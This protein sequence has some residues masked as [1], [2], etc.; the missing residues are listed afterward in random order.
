MTIWA[1]GRRHRL[2]DCSG[3][4]LR[5]ARTWHR[6]GGATQ[7]ASSMFGTQGTQLSY[8]GQ[9]FRLMAESLVGTHLVEGNI[10]NGEWSSVSDQVDVVTYQD[11][12][13][14]VIFVCAEELTVTGVDIQIDLSAFGQ[15]S[16]AW[17]ETI[18]TPADL[19]DVHD[20]ANMFT[21]Q[22]AKTSMPIQHGASGDSI[23]VDLV[24]DHEVV[25]IILAKATPGS[26]ALYLYGTDSRDRLVGGSGEDSLFG[27]DGYDSLTG[28]AG[29]D[30]LM[31]GAGNDS[32]IGEGGHDT[33]YGDAGAD[34]LQGLFG[35]DWLQG[36]AGAD[37]LS[38]GAGNDTLMGGDGLDF[39][40]GGGGH[41]TFDFATTLRIKEADRITDF[42]VSDD[43][44]RLSAEFF[45]G[46]V[47]GDLAASAFGAP[48]RYAKDASDRILYD[49][50]TGIIAFDV[51]GTGSVAPI[52]FALAPKGLILTAENFILV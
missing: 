13:K 17:A 15:L 50:G 18:R 5:R 36:G 43:M 33:L 46:M 27:N 39:L 7:A 34:Y 52:A 20:V 23:H 45:A 31:G 24:A 30:V 11:S 25:R 4:W 8:G 48:G 32:L 37:S 6:S 49:P 21:A 42:N 38:G 51:D 41:D 40:A 19:G 2:S 9:A 10:V 28:G 35:N 22:I 3:N 14:V 29:N 47:V 12:S 1:R 26:G 16:F 44:I